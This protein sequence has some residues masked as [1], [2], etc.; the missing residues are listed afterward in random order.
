MT[1]GPANRP[2]DLDWLEDFVVLSET[3]NFSRAAEARAIAQPAFSRHIRSLEEWVGVDLI[4]RTSHPVALTAAGKHFKTQV[5]EILI[6]LEGARLKARAEHD[7]AYATLSFACT[8]SLSLTYFPKWLGA[9]ETKLRLGSVQNMSDSLQGCMELMQQRR[10]Q[11]LLCY[12]H[13][14]VRDRLDDGDYPMHCLGH[15]TLVPVCASTQD[16]PLYSLEEPTSLPL[17]AYSE[18]SGLGRIF[19]TELEHHLARIR[20]TPQVTDSSVVFTA[21]NAFLLKAMALDGRGIAWL[22][23]SLVQDELSSGTLVEA[24]GSSWH[25]PLEV[26]LYRQKAEMSAPAEQVWQLALATH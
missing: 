18:S 26:R 12:G 5:S 24:G 13:A 10:A 7:Q 14:K 17:L 19:A 15:D 6:A 9:L 22:P 21:H 25:I 16:R 1:M 11:F 3:G 23:Q 2:L 4:D 8:H 20:N